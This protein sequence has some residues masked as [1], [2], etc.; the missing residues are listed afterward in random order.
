MPKAERIAPVP[1]AAAI[2]V[3]DAVSIGELRVAPLFPLLENLAL[4]HR[5]RGGDGGRLSAE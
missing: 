5:R 2:P 1:E 3:N 4:G